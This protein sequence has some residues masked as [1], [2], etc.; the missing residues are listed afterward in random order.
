MLPYLYFWFLWLC[1]IQ[2]F[3]QNNLRKKA[4]TELERKNNLI[5]AQK[6]EITDSIEYASRIQTAI[7]PPPEYIGNLLPQQFIVYRPRD[8]VSGDFYWIAEKNNRIISIVADCTGHGV[9]GAFMSMLGVAFL[10][11]IISRNA[12][13]TAGQILHE[14]REQV[15]VSLHQTGKEGESQ[16]GMDISLFILD[17]E[18]RSMQY[19][20]ANNSMIICRGD[21]L[22]E[23][24]AD[25]MPIG[26][27]T[28]ASE[29]FTNHVIELKEGDMLYAFTD[30]YPDQFGGLRGKKFM[31][32][33]FKKLLLDI[34]DK[35]VEEQKTILENTLDN[36]MANTTQVDDILIM[37][38]RV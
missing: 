24:K 16:D 28:K 11:E 18:K 29:P 17:K 8:I 13:I 25:K 2:L 33:N 34:R 14:L 30:G 22:I 19:A 27:H 23:L 3:R 4:Y 12:G 36:W 35:K 26:I 31:I 7:L 1:S 20:G 32:K 38:V 5:T 10:N 9:P 6:K 37:G 21:E 15:I